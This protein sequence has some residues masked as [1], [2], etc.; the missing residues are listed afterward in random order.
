MNLTKFEQ[1]LLHSAKVS[2]HIVVA[3]VVYGAAAYLV[4]HPVAIST[5]TGYGLSIGTVNAI[6]SG[7]WKYF[8][9]PNVALPTID[10][11]PNSPAQ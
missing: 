9:L 4:Q 10:T 5:L 7:I 6:L 8:S 1:A 11:A 2:L 3:L